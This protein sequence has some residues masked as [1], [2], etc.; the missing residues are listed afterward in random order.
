ARDQR[1]R[2]LDR[3]IN[4]LPHDLKQLATA[5]REVGIARDGIRRRE[6]R[7]EAICPAPDAVRQGRV[8]VADALRER[9]PQ[10]HVSNM[11]ANTLRRR[12]LTEVAACPSRSSS[13]LRSAAALSLTSASSSCGTESAVM[14]PPAPTV[15]PAPSITIVRM[16]IARSRRPSKPRYPNDPA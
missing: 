8:T 1:R 14:P 15:A 3:R 4:L 7:C 10:C 11:H 9:T 13:T 16:T 12:S 5:D 6:A 2:H